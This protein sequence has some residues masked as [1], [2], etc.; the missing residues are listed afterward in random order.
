MLSAPPT[1]QKVRSRYP[2]DRVRS[3]RALLGRF[4]AVYANWRAIQLGCADRIGGNAL[5]L[6]IST[7]RECHPPCRISP[8]IDEAGTGDDTLKV[9]PPVQDAGRPGC[10]MTNKPHFV[11]LGLSSSG[12]FLGQG[13]VSEAVRTWRAEPSGAGRRVKPR[14]RPVARRHGLSSMT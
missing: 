4:D 5:M 2:P 7:S 1:H 9:G 12:R 11:K 8:Q 3:D 14:T 13:N 10:S 6:L